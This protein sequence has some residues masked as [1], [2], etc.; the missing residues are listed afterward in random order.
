MRESVDGEDDESYY[1]RSMETFSIYEDRATLG[2]TL[3]GY[4]IEFFNEKNTL[5]SAVEPSE[6]LLGNDNEKTTPAR[7]QVEITWIQKPKRQCRL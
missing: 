1:K 2:E 3:E 4:P 5:E 7:A 6:P